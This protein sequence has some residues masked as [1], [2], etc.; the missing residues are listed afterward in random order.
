MQNI[1]DQNDIGM[2]NPLLKSGIEK[3]YNI[4][5]IREL[6][7]PKEQIDI[8]TQDLIKE[9]KNTEINVEGVGNVKAEK[10]IPNLEKYIEDNRTKTEKR[11][12]ILYPSMKIEHPIITDI[13]LAGKIFPYFV[14]RMNVELEAR[15]KEKVTAM[16]ILNS[17]EY[18]NF[19]QN[20]F[21]GLSIFKNYYGDSFNAAKDV[22]KF[23]K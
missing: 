2:D 23:L 12:D 10:L 22:N 17:L 1:E 14:E 9:I 19:T 16:E 20:L 11:A 7:E 4:N 6:E 21:K 3:Q 8:Y 15:G 13:K 18:E 5:D